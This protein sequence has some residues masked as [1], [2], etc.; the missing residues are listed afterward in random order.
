MRE[1]YLAMLNRFFDCMAGAV[2]NHGGEVLKF[3]GDAILAI[4]PIEDPDSPEAAE[5]AIEAALNAQRE[6]TQI[7]QQRAEQGAKAIGFGI[8]MHIGSL[9]YGNIGAPG[10]LDFTVIGRAVNEA[11][12]IEALCKSLQRTILVSRTVTDLLGSTDGLEDLGDHPPHPEAKYDPSR[13]PS[14][15][16][17][18]R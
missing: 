17:R 9:V 11:A 7:N 15:R 4:F 16:R 14:I 8:G 1:D 18:R 3:I 2:L 10:R 6:I 13:V 12:R 5:H